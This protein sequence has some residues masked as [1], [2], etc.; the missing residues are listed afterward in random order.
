MT[1]VAATAGYPATRETP[2]R[3]A[4]RWRHK[5]VVGLFRRTRSRKVREAKL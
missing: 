2:K 1:A 5:L 3:W 4:K